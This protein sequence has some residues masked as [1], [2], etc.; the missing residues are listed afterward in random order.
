MNKKLQLPFYIKV[1]SILVVLLAFGYLLIIGK[2]LLAPLVFSFI[3]AVSLL[4]VVYFLEDK[5]RFPKSLAAISA[6]LI[7]LAVILG[8]FYLLGAQI[9]KLSQE[10]PTFKEQIVDL[11]SQL[12]QWVRVKFHLSTHEQ[13]T[14]ISSSTPT[15]LNSGKNILEKTLISVSSTLVLFIF[16]LIYAFFILI[17]RKLFIRF[18]VVAFSKDNSEKIFEIAEQIKYIVKKYITGLMLETTIMV[19]LSFLVFWILGIPYML[20]LALLVGLLNLIPYIGIYI[21][22]AIACSITFTTTDL[23]HALYLAIALIVLHFIDAN[24]TMPKIVGSKVK[25]NPLIVILGVVTGGLIWG[26]A[27]MFLAIP[28]IGIAKVIFDRVHG[29]EAWGILLG[30]EDEDPKKLKN[31]AIKKEQE[32]ENDKL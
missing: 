24:I 27:G 16:M 19:T 8:I 28:I 22:M 13:N 9:A 30:D 4:P 18:L 3:F 2:T 10:W 23:N 17:Y 25:L 1:M 31:K 12:Q 21:A 5:L 11:Y 6:I 15:V 29:F 26:I 14:Y 32:I 20:L 7:A